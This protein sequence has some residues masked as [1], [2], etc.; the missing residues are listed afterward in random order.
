MIAGGR[1]SFPQTPV[2]LRSGLETHGND[3]G[4]SRPASVIQLWNFDS[5][6]AFVDVSCPNICSANVN[7][8]LKEGFSPAIR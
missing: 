6:R 7:L 2:V 3:A 8:P 5:L 4:F 1:L